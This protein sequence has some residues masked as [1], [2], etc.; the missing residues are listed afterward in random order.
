MLPYLT[1]CDPGDETTVTESPAKDWRVIDHKG[2]EIVVGSRVMFG[3]P[4]EGE[5]D[6]YTGIVTDI[7][8][9]DADYD[10]ELQR[11]VQ[12][13][14]K[15]TLRYGDGDEEVVTS[16]DV[17]RITWGDYPDGPIMQTFQADDLEVVT[18]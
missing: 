15:V 8:E 11:G 3:D 14:P 6:S 17:T 2:D 5:Q 13:P 10:D 18:G 16:Y 7:T 9:P 12:Y 4:A 1:N